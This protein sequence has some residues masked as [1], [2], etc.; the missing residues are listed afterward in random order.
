MTPNK[1]GLENKIADAAKTENKSIYLF[2][3]KIYK[4]YTKE[5]IT[6][7]RLTILMTYLYIY[8]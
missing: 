6:N 4:I 7:T 2:L 5:I 8:G 3:R 1:T